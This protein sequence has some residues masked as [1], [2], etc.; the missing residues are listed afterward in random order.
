MSNIPLYIHPYP[1]WPEYRDVFRRVKVSDPRL[2]DMQLQ[3]TPAEPECG[4]LLAFGEHPPFVAEYALIRRAPKE[5]GPDLARAILRWYCGLADDKRIIGYEDW[6]SRV[7]GM[8]V[9]EVA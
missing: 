1:R 3:P 6:L 8:D 7:L 4:R 9:R 2:R 5:L